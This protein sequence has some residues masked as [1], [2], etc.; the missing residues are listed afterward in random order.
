M[1]HN[2]YRLGI[3]HPRRRRRYALGS[4]R[5][6]PNCHHRP[7]SCCVFLVPPV[8]RLTKL[9]PSRSGFFTLFTSV[10]LS[11]H[12]TLIL[13]NSTTVEHLSV[14]RMQER[15]RAILSRM[16]GTFQFRCA[17]NNSLFK[18]NADVMNNSEKMTQRRKWDKEWGRIGMEGN[19][20]W[21][22]SMRL[23]WEARM[24]PNVWYWICASTLHISV[25]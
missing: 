12:V 18:A 1:E 16:F 4:D 8:A 20:W 17:L 21:L 10:L 6:S 2:L 14:E 25:T 13:F 23:N 19:I 3:Y 7:V 5:W 24:G 15:E 22:G 9:L 11:T